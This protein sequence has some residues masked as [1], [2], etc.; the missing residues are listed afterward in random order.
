MKKKLISAFTVFS[1]AI[2]NIFTIYANEYILDYGSDSNESGIIKSYNDITNYKLGYG[3]P[4]ADL[5]IT[6]YSSFQCTHCKNLHMNIEDFIYEKVSNG[7]LYLEIKVI[8]MSFFKY[9][10]YIFNRIENIDDLDTLSYIY[11]TYDI[12]TNFETYEELDDFFK[13]G[14]S[15]LERHVYQQ[16]NRVEL[17]NITGRVAVP[18]VM[19]NDVPVDEITDVQTLISAIYEV[20]GTEI[21]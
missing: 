4:D 17:K 18:Q 14:N 5:K 19:I 9:D 16:I 12:W 13:L 20:T 8:D 15:K 3:N 7:E 11:E 10:D 1:L 6:I 2:S 21:N